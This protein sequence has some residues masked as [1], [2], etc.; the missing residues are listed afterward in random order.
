MWPA[1]I[2]TGQTW[3][4]NRNQKHLF[5]LL[6]VPEEGDRIEPELSNSRRFF[7]PLPL[8]GMWQTT[9]GRQFWQSLLGWEVEGYHSQEC[10]LIPYGVQASC[11][12]S[13][14]THSVDDGEIGNY[15]DSYPEVTCPNHQVSLS[16]PI[17]LR[18]RNQSLDMAF[19]KANLARC[20]W[21]QWLW[22]YEG[23][24]K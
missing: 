19:H 14:P 18:P 21:E 17:F 23:R 2:L 9:V 3:F 10:C 12:V 22:V 4:K 6:F 8:G 24:L 1:S 20:S 5:S 13:V 11:P 16:P 15:K 7:T